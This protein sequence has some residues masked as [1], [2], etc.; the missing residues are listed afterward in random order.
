MKLS[1]YTW[2]WKTLFDFKQNS[3]KLDKNITSFT[4]CWKREIKIVDGETFRKC[5]QGLRNIDSYFVV[6][7]LSEF[8]NRGS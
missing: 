4:E 7:E 5:E 6:S 3:F 2:K 1:S 8:S